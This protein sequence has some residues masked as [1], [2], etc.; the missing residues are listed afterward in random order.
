MCATHVRVGHA[1]VK[2]L[3]HTAGGSDSESKRFANIKEHSNTH[4][5]Q[6]GPVAKCGK[7]TVV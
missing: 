2:K 1:S 4:E 3:L 5:Q 6:Y 7:S